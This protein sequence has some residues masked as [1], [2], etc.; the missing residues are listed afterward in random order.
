MNSQ[1]IDRRSPLLLT[2]L[3]ISVVIAV[4]VVLRRLYAFVSPNPN[5]PPQ[6]MALD[7]AFDAHRALTLAHILPALVFALLAPIVLLRRDAWMKPLLVA[8]GTV[9]G[10]T[11]YAMSIFAVGGLVEQTAIVLFNSLFLYWIWRAY[12]RNRQGDT[13]DARR[14]WIRAIA[15]LFGIA[16]TRPVMGF[17]FASSRLTGLHPEQ[18][19]GPAF[20]IGF[21]INT[22]AVEWWLSRHP[23]S[24][25]AR[26]KL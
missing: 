19:F 14:C 8:I 5:G 21:S 26:E 10:I 9:V 22:L 25:Y 20:W 2:G 15:I 4:A 6:M 24:A 11:A 16:T 17:F 23:R 1:V 3:W 13:E 7:R 12:L 18:F